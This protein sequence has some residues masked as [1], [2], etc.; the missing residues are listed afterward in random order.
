MAVLGEKIANLEMYLHCEEDLNKEL[1]KQLAEKDKRIQDLEERLHA[2][3]AEVH[4][5]TE[6]R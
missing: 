6:D 1:K 4:V 2:A 5:L 3:L